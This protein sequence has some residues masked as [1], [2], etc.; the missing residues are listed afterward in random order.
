MGTVFALHNHQGL[1]C[2][3]ENWISCV[4]ILFV[5]SSE[6]SS[7]VQSDE[8]QFQHLKL[9]ELHKKLQTQL[10]EVDENNIR[11][12]NDNVNLQTKILK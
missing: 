3:L 5:I 10:A 12:Q 7:D 8:L 11:L 1:W 9:Q 6:I 2:F 4:F